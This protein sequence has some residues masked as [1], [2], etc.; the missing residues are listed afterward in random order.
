MDPMDSYSGVQKELKAELWTKISEISFPVMRK[1]DLQM[2][3]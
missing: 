1:I 3:L 2:C